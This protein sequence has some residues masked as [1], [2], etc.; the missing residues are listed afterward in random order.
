VVEVDELPSTHSGKRSERAATDALNGVDSRNLDALSN[1][2]SLDQLRLAVET[3]EVRGEAR[4]ASTETTGERSTEERLRAIWEQV[5][6][7]S[8]L[9]PDDNF[10]DVGGTSLTTVQLF[11]A[12]HEQMGLDPPLSIMFEAQ[13]TAAMA[14]VLDRLGDERV[15]QMMLL[16]EGAAGRPLFVIHSLAG[17]VLELRPLTLRLSTDRPVW[18][19]LARG[20]DPR[21]APHATIEEMADD[22]IEKIREVQ[23]TGPYALAGYSFGG[24]VAYEMARR[25]SETGEELDF[26]GLVDAYVDHRCLPAPSRWIFPL[27]RL[28]RSRLPSFLR[29]TAHRFAPDLRLPGQRTLTAPLPPVHRRLEKICGAALEAY[30]PSPSPIGVVFFRGDEREADLCD[31][32]PVWSRLAMGGLTIEQL[33][34]G[35]HAI[36]A[37]PGVSVLAEHLAPYL[38]GAHAVGRP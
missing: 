20:L 22:Y 31:P 8:P 5:L 3:A 4:A 27:I 38:D 34:G 7:I 6:G 12:I 19:V 36:L 21:Q 35:H 25:L 33:P 37:E 17:D 26:V 2:H 24:L 9:R 13:T 28:R 11:Q 14:E 29:D 16:S 23:P 1:P 30:R 10:F 15:P 32:L 18:G